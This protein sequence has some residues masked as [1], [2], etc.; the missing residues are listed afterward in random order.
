MT[1]RADLHVHTTHSDGA[2]APAQVV[3]LARRCGLSAIAITDHDTLGGIVPAQSAASG[4]DL[5]IVPG[6]EISAEYRGCEL[7]LLGYFVQVDDIPL[8]KALATLGGQRCERFHDMVERLR[9]CGVAIEEDA[10]PTDAAGHVLGRR[11]LALALV[12]ARRARSVREAFI[13]YLGD[14]GQIAVPKVRL[15]VAQAIALVRGAGGVASWAHPSYHCQRE[16][17][18]EL[19][20]SGLGAV[21]VEY[22]G[23]RNGRVREL[24]AWATELGLAVTGGSDCHGPESQNR[25]LGIRTVSDN[26]LASLR[27][28][29]AS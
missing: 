7:H 16:T 4:L 23:F 29:A 18:A 6:V 2:Y 17:L 13:R 24:R 28:R 1:G 14:H 26:E 25:A 19:S 20:N 27:Q 22:P 9:R 5:E 15:P 3:D 11:H 12:K 8:R 10:L 21:E